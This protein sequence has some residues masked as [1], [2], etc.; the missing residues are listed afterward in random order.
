MISAGEKIIRETVSKIAL[1]MPML[2]CSKRRRLLGVNRN[3]QNLLLTFNN[4]R[5]VVPLNAGNR[6]CSFIFWG[7]PL[8]ACSYSPPGKFLGVQNECGSVWN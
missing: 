6:F 5:D 4:G 8:I 3:F 1:Q 7:G 2:E